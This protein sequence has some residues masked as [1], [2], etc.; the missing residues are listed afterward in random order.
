MGNSGRFGFVALAGPPNVGKS[1]LLNRILGHK[2]SI[3]SRRP[4]TT[5]HRILGVKTCPQFQIVFVDTPGLHSDHRKGL[6]RVLNKT[7]LSSLSDVDLIVFMIDFRGWDDALVKIFSKAGNLA[8]PILLVI[9]KID[10]LKDKNRLLPLIQQSSRMH[11]FVDIVPISA[12]RPDDVKKLTHLV[13]TYMPGGPPG[14]P[15][16]QLTDR[17]DRFFAAELVREQ[18][19][20]T[21]GQE[22]PYSVAVEITEFETG[23]NGVLNVGA[24]IWVE[25]QGQKSIVIGKDGQQLKKIG[26]SARLQME[27]TFETRVFLN[28]WVKLKKGWADNAMHL[29]SL[30]YSE[31]QPP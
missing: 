30:G 4:Q 23:K 20:S 13:S 31:N 9:N 24:T 16:D 27:S 29:R 11:E 25:K 21:L 10:T 2:V 19:F 15:E 18:V 1:T 17:S 5:R 3:V 7:A 8:I 6:N 22:L 12:F 14:Y 28:I 26:T